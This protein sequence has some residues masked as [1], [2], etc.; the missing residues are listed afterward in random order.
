MDLKGIMLNELSLTE[1]G[2]YYIWFHLY[3]EPK[4]QNKWTTI[5]E[6]SHKYKEQIG[7][8]RGE[9]FGGGK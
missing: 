9:G 1:K 3:V 7:V 4:N 6:Q 8:A 5:S 2:K